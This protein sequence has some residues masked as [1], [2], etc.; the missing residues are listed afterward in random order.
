MINKKVN[1]FFTITTFLSTI[2][3]LYT[4]TGTNVNLLDLL[5]TIELFFLFSRNTKIIFNKNRKINIWLFFLFYYACTLFFIRA[6]TKIYDSEFLFSG[7]KSIFY[8]FFLLINYKNMIIDNKFAIKFFKSI[9]VISSILI[10]IQNI[11]LKFNIFVNGYINFIPFISFSA[12]NSVW[13]YHLS[14]HSNY[15]GL[16]PASIFLEPTEYAFYVGLY[17]ILS[18]YVNDF[19]IKKSECII[20]LGIIISQ[21][22]LGFLTLIFYYLLLIFNLFFK[23]KQYLLVFRIICLI[24]FTLLFLKIFMFSILRVIFKSLNSDTSLSFNRILDSRL[25]LFKTE[26]WVSY[27]KNNVWN[28]LLGMG[29]GYEKIVKKILPFGYLTGI[30]I[31]FITSGI[32]GIVLYYVFLLTSI[33]KK[34]FYIIIYFIISMFFTSNSLFMDL[35]FIIS[36]ANILDD[37]YQIDGTNSANFKNNIHTLCKGLG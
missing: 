8:S 3:S 29:F 1:I 14:H 10:I 34:N 22:S 6:I 35:F 23:K 21:S 32:I 25:V 7:L 20:I 33:S 4:I 28:Y 17:L 19:K 18:I 27:L 24:I 31:L 5:F 2:L 26:K 36:I 37:T 12:T 9:S 11:C 13:W 30:Q 15:Y 16:R